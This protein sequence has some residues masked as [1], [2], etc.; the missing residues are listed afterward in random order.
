MSLS[1]I[2]QNT[3]QVVLSHTFRVDETA[4]DATGTVAATLKR[5]DGTTVHTGN[6]TSAGAGTGT[7]NYTPPP[8]AQLN[9]L[10]L[11]WSGTVAGNAVVERDI[12]EVV[13]GFLFDL[14]EARAKPPALDATRYPTA[15]LK[16]GR[17]EVEIECERICRVAWVPRYKRVAIDTGWRYTDRL[18]TPDTQLRALR[19]V[20]V[21]GTTWTVDQV[22]A[23]TVS[24]SGVLT[25]PACQPWPVR[26]RI[27]LEYEHG[28]DFPPV[29]VGT[30][31]MVRLRS[32]LGLFDTSVPYRAISFTSGE[33][34]TYRLSTPSKDRTGIPE[35]DA[36]YEGNAVEVGG[37]A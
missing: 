34:G 10:T 9:A 7:Y 26:S 24:E 15:M 37:F 6:A 5:L 11:D 20:T 17:I 19:S 8:Q 36:A 18:L 31:G 13:G 33:G 23:V 28:F 2:L 16:A 21:N 25:L 27:I 29:D 30:A 1:R 35:V 4:T 32:R 14:A 3:A 12:V 22:N